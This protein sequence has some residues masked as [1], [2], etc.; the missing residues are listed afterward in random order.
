MQISTEIQKSTQEYAYS[1]Y[2]PKVD[3]NM[4]TEQ[5]NH[6]VNKKISHKNVQKS[7]KA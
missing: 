7:S 6:K 5:Q 3:K 4:Y 2:S 1:T